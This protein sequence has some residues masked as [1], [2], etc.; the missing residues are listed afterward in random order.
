[1]KIIL[2]GSIPKGDEVRKSWTDW[3]TDYI[4]KLSRAI[5]DVN[6]LHGDLISDKEGPEIVVG[7]DLYLIK[8]SDIAIVHATSKIGAGT[9]QEILMAKQFN[10][11]VIAIIPKD[12]HHRKSNVVFHGTLIDDFIN[13][14]LFI[15]TDFVAESIEDAIT[16]IKN[17]SKNS[18]AIK[19]K[20][21]SVM[22]QCIDIFEKQFPELATKYKNQGW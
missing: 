16:W 17:Y 4:Q 21:F 6:F 11:P 12:T 10:K 19:I 14:F 13:P 1:M 7:H 15:S 5:P 2:L 3:K 8:H 22:E 18:H 9:A 20:D